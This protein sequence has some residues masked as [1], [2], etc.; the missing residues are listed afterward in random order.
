MKTTL[1]QETLPYI[2]RWARKKFAESLHPDFKMGAAIHQGKKKVIGVGCNDADRTH[3]KIT[4]HLPFAQTV[5]AELAAIMD[6]KNKESLKGA[7]MV[8]YREKKDGSLGMSRPCPS[9]MRLLKQYGFK[10]IIYTTDQGY[11]EEK[12][13]VD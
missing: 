7:T 5:H 13:L 4:Q 8:V 1:S 6:V 9:C 11:A 10:K 3:P 12:I 2:F